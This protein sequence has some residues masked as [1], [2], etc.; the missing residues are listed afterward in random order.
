MQKVEGDLSLRIW[1]MR[2]PEPKSDNCDTFN[3]VYLG[4]FGQHSTIPQ[5]VISAIKEKNHNIYSH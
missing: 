4:L 2:G 3:T 1:S 5:K